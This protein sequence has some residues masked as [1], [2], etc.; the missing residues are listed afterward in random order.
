[1]SMTRINSENKVK[2]KDCNHEK[3]HTSRVHSKILLRSILSVAVQ[4]NALCNIHCNA[5]IRP[6]GPTSIILD[7]KMAQRCGVWQNDGMTS[8]NQG[9]VLVKSDSSGFWTFWT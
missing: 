9:Q 7:R 8:L 5:E 6:Q 4:C 3:Y 2:K 1:M